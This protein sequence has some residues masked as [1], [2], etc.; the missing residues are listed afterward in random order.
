[1]KSIREVDFKNIE[2]PYEATWDQPDVQWKYQVPSK[3]V[4]LRNG[5]WAANEAFVTF[6]GLTLEEVL[7]GDITGDG[8]EEAVAVLRF[9]TGGTMN[10]H[11]IYVFKM[12]E[13]LPRGIATY[14]TGERSSYGLHEI[15]MQRQELVVELYDPATQLALCCSSG[16]ER[17]RYQWDGRTFRR[18]GA[19]ERAK[20]KSD[21]R[22][23][24]DFFGMAHDR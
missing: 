11:H 18:V 15:T 6:S 4:K 12:R 16:I 17:T 1:P 9:D 3:S 8:A 22:R 19:V 2:I 21:S 23:P 5:Q 13:N 7:Y 14:G 10:W 24:I 20:A